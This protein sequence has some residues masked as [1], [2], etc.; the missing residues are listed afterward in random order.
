MTADGAIEIST[1][2]QQVLNIPMIVDI[3]VAALD[4][5]SIADKIVRRKVVFSGCLLYVAVVFVQ[6]SANPRYDAFM[7]HAR[8]QPGA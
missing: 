4:G 1:R 7:G 8:R 6:D 5:G 2:N 3:L